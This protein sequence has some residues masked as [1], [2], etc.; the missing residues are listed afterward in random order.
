MQ[1][2]MTAWK[3]SRK[4]G[5]V[6]GGRK[7]PKISDN[8]FARAHSLKRPDPNQNLPILIVDN[9]SRDF[10]FPLS[11]DEVVQA[12]QALPDDDHD[13]ITHIWLRRVKKADYIEGQVPLANLICGSGV[14]VIV[15]Y[16]FSKDMT[17]PYG[18]K[19]PSNRVVNEVEKYGA[20]VKKMSSG[21][22][23]KWSAEGVRQYYIQALLYSC[24][25]THVDWYNRYWSD[26]N[27]KMTDDFSD[28]YAVAKTATAI[29]V[30]NKLTKAEEETN[31]DNQRK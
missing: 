22:V 16:A 9:P 19:R 20:V 6:Y 1:K 30:F 5:D 10:F 21:W 13:G 8:I 3:K 12:M 18:R 23:S 17:L 27:G 15:L 25:G 7:W 11:G 28:E 4:F 29:H 14:R 26:A 2:K 31:N 24:V